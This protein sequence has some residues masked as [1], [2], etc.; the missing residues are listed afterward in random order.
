V[1]WEFLDLRCKGYQFRAF[2]VVKNSIKLGK[3][4]LKGKNSW[5]SISDFGQQQKLLNFIV[6]KQVFV[7]NVPK[8]PMCIDCPITFKF[9]H[10]STSQ[11]CL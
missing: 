8:C 4:V 7:S 5:V 1:I 10:C 3:M 6:K 2:Y 11:D 9:I